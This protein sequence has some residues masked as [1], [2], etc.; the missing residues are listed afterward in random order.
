LRGRTRI[1][2]GI[3]VV[4]L[5]GGGAFVVLDRGVSARDGVERP[6]RPLS[7]GGDPDAVPTDPD[8]VSTGAPAVPVVGTEA[9][10]HRARPSLRR[11]AVTP[12]VKRELRLAEETDPDVSAKPALEAD[13]AQTFSEAD[14][15]EQTIGPTHPAM[16]AKTFSVEGQRNAQ[17][18]LRVVPP[19]T[20]GDVGTTQ[21]VQMVNTLW[22]VYDKTDGSKVAGGGPF[23]LSSL[24]D[25]GSQKLC[26]NHDDG[27]PVVVW[28]PIANR[29]LLSQFALNFNANV[30]AE[31]I[32]VSAGEDATGVWYAYQFRYPRAKTLPDYPKFGVWPDAYYASF[33]QFKVSSTGRFS[34]GGAGAVAYDRTAM[35]AGAPA[36]QIYMNL[37]KTDINLGGMLP[38][39]LDGTPPPSGAPNL[40]A[41]VDANEWGY[42][43]DQIELWAF[44]TDWATPDDST[45]TP[46]ASNLHHDAIKTKAFN[47]W[48]C[49]P[50]RV[51][52]VP[53]KG[54][55][56]RLDTLS[57]RAMFRLQYR[58]FGGRETLTFTQSVRSSSKTAGVR[59]YIL[60]D[61]GPGWGIQDQGTFAPADGRYRWMGSA[62][63]D[64]TG[65]L[66]VGYS[67]SSKKMFP[68]IAYAGKLAADVAAHPGKL[69]QGERRVFK[70][71]GSEKG[72]Y[73]RWGDYS[74]LTVDPVDECTFFYTQQYYGKTGQWGWRTRI[75]AFRYPSC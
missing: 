72:G 2:A 22:S 53:Q 71:A 64:G 19:D 30:Y 44:H 8:L 20:N 67:I 63:L 33:N 49:R 15:A 73:S 18:D 31:C 1:V 25:V 3:A 36:G 40:Y 11:A 45:F 38:S 23:T 43:R 14:G 46:I 75:V 66:A 35:L 69:S 56:N 68:S 13:R 24:F 4:A 54:S 10:A 58:N 42:P 5:A 61:T 39:D 26:A 52:C 7:A 51:Y 50:G 55:K 41:Q 59:W 48:I 47:P 6:Q 27:D 70:G 37:A 32:A 12:W 9:R 62:A 65:D 29:W 21:Y 16:P 57:D 17:N 60:Q 28:D 74:D 34:W